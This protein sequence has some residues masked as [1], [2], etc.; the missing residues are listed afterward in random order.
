MVLKIQGRGARAS[1]FGGCLAVVPPAP[2]LGPVLPRV[3]VQV[4]LGQQRRLLGR[5]ATASLGDL[6][7]P[8]ALRAAS[9]GPV[10]GPPPGNPPGGRR[11][12][13]PASTSAALKRSGNAALPVARPACP[14]PRKPYQ[15]CPHP[16][17]RRPPLEPRA[18]LRP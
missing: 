7:G 12:G 16:P 10:I 14:V 5:D 17:P 15:C 11:L 3:H 4:P 8:G 13:R 6:A 2:P 9:P 1:V 18:R